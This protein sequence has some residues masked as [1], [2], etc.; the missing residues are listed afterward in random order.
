MDDELMEWA[1]N[2]NEVL[3][4]AGEPMIDMDT[5]GTITIYSSDGETRWVGTMTRVED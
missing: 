3:E 1:N 5:D 2:L 4:Q